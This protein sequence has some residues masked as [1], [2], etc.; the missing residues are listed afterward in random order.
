LCVTLLKLRNVVGMSLYI[1]TF[2][3]MYVCKHAAASF[4]DELASSG[5]RSGLTYNIIQLHP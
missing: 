2:V 5:V 1:C 3:D 4:I